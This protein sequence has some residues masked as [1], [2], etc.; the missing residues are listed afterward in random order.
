MFKK[1]ILVLMPILNLPFMLMEE[2]LHEKI[3][4]VANRFNIRS[5]I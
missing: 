4:G 5:Y 1:L 3:N 2:S